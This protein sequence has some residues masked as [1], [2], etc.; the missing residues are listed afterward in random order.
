MR[1]HEREVFTIRVPRAGQSAADRARAASR[2]LETVMEQLE[3]GV[4]AE[5]R[6]EEEG[7]IAVVFVGKSPIVTVDEADAT[8]EGVTLRVLGATVATRVQEVLRIEKKRSVIATTVFSFSLLVFS[9]LMAFLLLRRL[10]DF[11]DKLRVWLESHRDRLPALRLGKIEVVSSAAVRGAITIAARVGY[12]L[13]QLA[14]PYFWLLIALSLFDATRGYTEKLTGFV[15]TPFAAL[16][17]RIGSAL[18][19]LVVAIIA[20]AAVL[21]VVRFVGLFFGTVARGETKVGWL[22]S[23]LAKPTSVLVRTGIVIVSLIV[24]SPLITGSDE[25]TL[26]RAGVAALVTVALACM[27]ILACA[28]VGVPIVFGRR[29]QNGDF[30][31]MGGRA[32]RVH[33]ITL[34][35]VRLE[36]VFGCEVRVPHL[37]T[38]WHP[39]RVVGRS[40]MVT[41]D[42]VV[43]PKASQSMVEDVLLTAARAMSARAKVELS[44]LDSDGASYRVT[45]AHE[46]GKSLAVLVAD[47]LEAHAIA[48]GRRGA[49]P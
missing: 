14:V 23:D 24:A 35:E 48:L 28:A 27:P 2:A 22:S 37:L 12:R 47:A 4:E 42:V 36:D 39:T 16:L 1:V 13:A 8:A 29:L 31:E 43:D 18:P 11:D 32:G 15:V 3:G 44:T 17:Q 40:R 19:V 9:A 46:P 10:G 34:L 33:G 21:L 6:V 45:C 41:V 20:M 25:G 49:K 38:L 26:A 7:T 30:V 5:A